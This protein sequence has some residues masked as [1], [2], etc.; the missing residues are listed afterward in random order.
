MNPECTFSHPGSR[1]LSASLFAPFSPIMGG[2]HPSIK[3]T[4]DLLNGLHNRLLQLLGDGTAPQV[5]VSLILVVMHALWC[6]LF[7]V[8]S[9]FT[10]RLRF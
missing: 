3:E 6:A 1:V 5:R 8:Q 4:S 2:R 7:D 10:F 9:T